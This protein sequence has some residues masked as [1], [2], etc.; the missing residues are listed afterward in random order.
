[1]N[2]CGLSLGRIE[3]AISILVKLHENLNGL[4][5]TSRASSYPTRAS[6]ASAAGST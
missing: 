2:E 6:R 1:M 5:T 4:A 3:P